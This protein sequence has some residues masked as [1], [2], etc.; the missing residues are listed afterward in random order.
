MGENED[1]R[2]GKERS[3]HFFIQPEWPTIRR[4]ISFSSQIRLDKKMND[5]L[6]F[7]ISIVQSQSEKYKHSQ[8]RSPTKDVMVI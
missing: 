3:L 7:M 1:R 2:T 5:Y 8:S 4:E 6:C